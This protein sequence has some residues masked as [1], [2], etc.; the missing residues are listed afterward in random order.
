[1]ATANTYIALALIEAR[2]AV[3]LG[4]KPTL[5]EVLRVAYPNALRHKS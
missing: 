5:R 3:E 2:L 4:R 1:M